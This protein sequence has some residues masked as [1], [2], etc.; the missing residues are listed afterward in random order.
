M[1]YHV[2]MRG[3]V[4]IIH[5]ETPQAT[6]RSGADEFRGELR[7][8]IEAGGRYLVIHF[9][10]VQHADSTMLEALVS[11]YRSLMD[12]AGDVVVCGLNETVA[13]SFSLSGLDRLLRKYPDVESAVAALS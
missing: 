8:M 3:R 12:G 4:R 13:T 5:L 2:E 1:K 6:L 9:G 7:S 10:T 11:A